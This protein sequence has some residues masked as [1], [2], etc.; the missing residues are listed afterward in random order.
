[1]FSGHF[2]SFWSRRTMFKS[3]FSWNACCFVIK[4]VKNCQNCLLRPWWRRL[5]RGNLGFIFLASVF[6]RTLV[7][8][9]W[10][11]CPRP[12]SSPPSSFHALSGMARQTEEWHVGKNKIKEKKKK[13]QTSGTTVK[14]PKSPTNSCL[15]TAMRNV[16][17][18]ETWAVVARHGNSKTNETLGERLSVLRRLHGSSTTI[19]YFSL[20]VTLMRSQCSFNARALLVHHDSTRRSQVNGSL[21]LCRM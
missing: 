3:W 9:C 6:V 8:L 7:P 12:S 21:L 13:S 2:W 18:E 10:C 11:V 19:R 14:L 20:N 15:T 1:M 4:K 17:K 16:L 5:C